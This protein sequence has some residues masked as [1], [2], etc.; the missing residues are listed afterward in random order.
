MWHYFLDNNPD[1]DYPSL[2]WHLFVI[3]LPL[4]YR[5]G[6]EFNP[7]VILSIAAPIFLCIN[8]PLSR[9]SQ[10]IP[11]CDNLMFTFLYGKGKYLCR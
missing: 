10:K 9:S 5:G 7:F 4:N 3:Y 1:E 11:Q 8:L 6:A 2:T